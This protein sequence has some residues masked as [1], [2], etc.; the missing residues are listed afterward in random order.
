[1]HEVIL[2]ELGLMPLWQ[3]RTTSAVMADTAPPVAIESVAGAEL[4]AITVQRENGVPGRVLM[5]KVM[6]A[7][8]ATLFVN[9]LQAMHLRQLD[10]V[11]L[12]Y[13]QLS[14]S[15]NRGAVQWLWLMGDAL[16]QRMLD[17]ESSVAELSQQAV[18][19]QSL[20]VF[21]SQHPDVLL[22]RHQEKSGV[23]AGWCSWSQPR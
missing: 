16:A 6:S 17:T 19:W 10:S 18:Y 15:V 3:L 14:D 22:L 5:D 23:W 7:D 12:D 20:P 13:A 1:M 11:Q 2:E 4:L 21:V 9:M 8:A